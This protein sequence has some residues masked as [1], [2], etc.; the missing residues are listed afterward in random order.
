MIVQRFTYLVKRGCMPQIIEL[1]KPYT[2]K[3]TI[4]GNP[5]R[6]RTYT[7]SFGPSDMIVLDFEFE[8]MDQLEKKWAE[9]LARPEVP[10][11]FEKLDSLFVPGGSNEI[12]N[13][14]E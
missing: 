8:N 5:A 2:G 1:L 9:W 7:S 13:L 14:V 4:T 10:T 3:G 12:W 11:L 6:E